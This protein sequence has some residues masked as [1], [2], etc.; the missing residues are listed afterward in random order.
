MILYHGTNVDI[1]SISL[2]MCRPYKD[3]GKGFYLTSLE[4]QARKMAYRVS[5]IYG[6][7]PVINMYEIDNDFLLDKELAIM[8]FGTEVTEKWAT[9]VMNN[10][11]RNFFDYGKG[12]YASQKG[13]C[14]IWIKRNSSWSISPRTLLNISFRILVWSMMRQ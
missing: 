4:E 10:R 11:N 9:F 8:D 12:D 1:A 3:F 6:G 7:K 2:N 13:R 14:N 5:K